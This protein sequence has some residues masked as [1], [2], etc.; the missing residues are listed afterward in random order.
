MHNNVVSLNRKYLHDY[1]H[2]MATALSGQGHNIKKF[3]SYSKVL[4][5]KNKAS[6]IPYLLVN[7]R[8]ISTSVNKA[9]KFNKY[10]SEQCTLPKSTLTHPLPGFQYVANTCVSI[11]PISPEDVHKMLSQLDINK[12]VGPDGTVLAIIF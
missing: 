6:T 3:W 5:G 11:V 10:F 7:G 2:K 4:L 1:T 8:T 9:T 12:S